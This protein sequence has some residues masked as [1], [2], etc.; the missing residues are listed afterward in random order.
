MREPGYPWASSWLELNASIHIVIV[1]C[2]AL[3]R[4]DGLNT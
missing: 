1:N 3:R 4:C 2:Q